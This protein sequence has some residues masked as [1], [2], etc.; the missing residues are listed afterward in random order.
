MPCRS[1]QTVS[2]AQP[3]T[4]LSSMSQQPNQTANHNASQQQHHQSQLGSING[5]ASAVA[6]AVNAAQQQQL[7]TSQQQQVSAVAS[8]VALP[9]QLAAAQA[10]QQNA[11]QQQ[12]GKKPSGLR[13]LYTEKALADIKNSL[14]P[15][16]AADGQPLRPVSS[17]STG[18]SNNSDYS[19]II[20]SL[21]NM[22]FDE[23]SQEFYSFIVH[24]TEN[25]YVRI[26]RTHM[27]CT[28]LLQV[29]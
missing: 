3:T 29:T 2:V 8:A 23:V 10:Q 22:G 9:L 20:L 1:P 4:Y 11:Q 27:R 24:F 28:H 7:L 12:N 25:F 26:L 13:D 15:Y 21:M 17:L 16:E 6:A 5:R 18:S 14:R 19:N